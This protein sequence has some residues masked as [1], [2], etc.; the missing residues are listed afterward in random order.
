MKGVKVVLAASTF[1][2]TS[3][4]GMILAVS[5]NVGAVISSAHASNVSFDQQV[6]SRE[7]SER[8]RGFDNEKPG[9]KHRGR[10]GK[11]YEEFDQLA[12]EASEGPRGFDNEKPG[13]KHRGRRGKAIEQFELVA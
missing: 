1:V 4:I 12:R 2:G 11:A 5:S 9:D 8:P 7:A 10:G 6:I 3:L 13:D